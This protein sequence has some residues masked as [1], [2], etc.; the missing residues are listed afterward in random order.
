[1]N[2]PDV[3]IVLI[4]Y[5][6]AARIGR[7]ID[8]ALGQTLHRL[9]VIVVDDCSTDGTEA[10]VRDRMLADPRLRYVRLSENSGG[11]SAPRNRGML[12]AQGTWLM[13]CDSDDELERHAAKN[14]LLAVEA[15]DADLGCGVVERVDVTTGKRVRWRAE[16]HDVATLHGLGDRPELIA[17]T[18]SVNKIYRRSWLLEHGITFPEGL[19]YEDQLFTI[20]AYAEAE[21][22]AVLDETVYRWY[23]ER[24][25]EELSI[26]QRRKELRNVRDR[27]AVN[28]LIDDYLQ[29]SGRSDLVTVKQAKFLRH[30]TYLYLG[31]VL[32]ADD[33][34]AY[35]IM[36]EL[37]EY[38][39]G[40]D[41][42][43]CS[44][45]RAPLRV[46][47][48]HLML[49]DLAGV[50]AAMKT[51]RWS[52]TIPMRL[53]TVA[54]QD[55]WACEHLHNG[56]EVGGLSPLW[57][58]DVTAL[59]PS[60]APIPDQRHCHEIER[61]EVHGATL[62]VVGSTTDAYGVLERARSVLLAL[63]IADQTV[64][65]LP[66]ESSFTDGRLTWHAHGRLQP[67]GGGRV[68]AHERGVLSLV[69]DID[70]M[71]NVM[72]VRSA[73]RI[74][75]ALDRPAITLSSG[76]A[77]TVTWRADADRHLVGRIVGRLRGLL[78]H[79]TARVARLLPSRRIAIFMSDGSATCDGAPLAMSAFLARTEPGIRQIWV[80]QRRPGRVP[81]FATA[82]RAGGLKHRWLAARARWWV[83]DGRPM[84]VAG[85]GVSGATIARGRKTRTL[86]TMGPTIQR[87]GKDV[88]D[89]PLLTASKQRALRGSGA[90]VVAASSPFVRDVV[91]PALDI[92]GSTM[93]AAP[94]AEAVVDRV[95]ARARLG[96]P[97]DRPVV[98]WAMVGESQPTLD[99]FVRM[100]DG[101]MQV[102]VHAPN[103][104]VP[105]ALRAW[106][107]D[108]SR[109]GDTANVIASCDVVVTDAS[110]LAMVA[111]AAGR[112]VV[113]YAPDIRDL[114]SRGLGLYVEWPLQAPGPIAATA[115]DVVD[116]VAETLAAHTFILETYRATHSDFAAQGVVDAAGSCERAWLALQE[117]PS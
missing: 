71:R 68:D 104:R 107:R 44:Q 57:W 99:E 77:A 24:L 39:R 81:S 51:V 65:E 63:T 100:V 34:T 94:L 73:A 8:S 87:V 108:V 79:P 41:L 88:V 64:A 16:L 59:H 1:M 97:A 95:D 19:L 80:Y 23:V 60:F 54:G 91:V 62:D 105:S 28:R 27:I 12:E 47:I 74:E 6:D 45:L 106:A 35:A 84:V 98:L 66:L 86:V 109:S 30:E 61:M 117:R 43:L 116:A 103:G 22:I 85:S 10:L 49:G 70:G 7:A 42:S 96:L 92:G 101:T 115:R 5:N 75:A 69:I 55:L 111:A 13:F 32:E 3:S 25:S 14:L 20:R 40:A 29:E 15:A 93:L 102:L 37:A 89:W 9:E 11:C 78:V 52:A 50:R 90:D 17:D 113:I 33:E 2:G 82:V 4:S 53:E 31:A 26:T 21:R 110:P 72:P 58:L 18:V 83:T 56:P 114:A 48:Y 36:G 112:P 46:A 76:E 67:V 38:L